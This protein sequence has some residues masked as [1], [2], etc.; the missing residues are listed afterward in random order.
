MT[1]IFTPPSSGTHYFALSGK[2]SRIR[3][4]SY[5]F[6]GG[7][8]NLKVWTTSFVNFDEL[9]APDEVPDLP[10][11]DVFTRGFVMVNSPGTGTQG[12]ISESGDVDW[13]AVWL[14]KPTSRITLEAS[15][16]RLGEPANDLAG[17]IQFS[18]HKRLDGLS[19]KSTTESHRIA[20]ATASPGSE[21]VEL[22]YTLPP[23]PTPGP[24]IY[25][26]AVSATDGGT[27]NYSLK[28]ANQGLFTL[29]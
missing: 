23:K 22:T 6:A 24:G 18:V 9:T 3:G 28:V 19:G 2:G 27:G 5:K 29:T 21:R 26:I 10:G 4:H 11:P 8:G 1:K 13:Y 16:P 20:T 12:K 15:A 14:D 17:K 7:Y 25:W